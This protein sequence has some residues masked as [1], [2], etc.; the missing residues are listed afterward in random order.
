M[1]FFI[2]STLL[3]F[4][5]TFAQTVYES[6][7]SEALGTSRELKIQ[8]PR[9][10]EDNPEKSY[11]LI[12]VFDGDYLF[13]VV[14]GN[15]DYY[16]Y[17]DDM[18][19]AI[20]VGINQNDLRIEDCS[21][22]MEDYLPSETGARFYDFIENELIN[23]MIENYRSLDFRVAIGHGETANFMNYFMFN[24][25]PIF[26]AYVALS[27][28]LS[29]KMDENLT[30]RLSLESNDKT[31]YYLSTGTRDIKQNK[32]EAIALNTTIS[33]FENTN[34][35]YTFDNFED[36]THYTLVAHSI[37]KALQRIFF[38]FQPISKSEYNDYILPLETSPVSYLNEK[39]DMIKTL[40]GIEKQILV[41]DFRAIAAAIERTKQYEYF[42]DLAKIASKHHPDTIMASFYLARYYEEIGKLKKAMNVYRSAY[43][44]NEIE[45]YSKDDMLERADEIKAEYGD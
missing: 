11:P 12:V 6:I 18:L 40:F 26:N 4:N 3:C 8:L 27:P 5:L 13:E 30:R 19:E 41:N 7:D 24:S 45:G 10:Y 2:I 34:L 42:Q 28:S 39:Y 38:V 22:S 36:A 32:K 17:W 29:Y 25:R 37:P 23:Y 15:V 33:T 9:N 14:A 35:L 21:I 44:L 43:M 31:F 16:S 20:V 1:K